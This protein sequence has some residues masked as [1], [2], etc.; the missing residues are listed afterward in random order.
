MLSVET[1][2]QE[3]ITA[4]KQRSFEI[5]REVLRSCSELAECKSEDIER[6]V[7]RA[8]GE[9]EHAELAGWFFLAESGELTNVFR[10]TPNPISLCS[11]FSNGLRG[12]PWCLSQLNAGTAVLID[13]VNE[14]PE[15]AEIDRQSLKDAAVRSVAL[16]PSNSTS[17]GHTI[18]ILLSVSNE[19]NWSD[20]INEQ[21]ALLETM[22]SIASQRMPIREKPQTVVKYFEQL[23]A[24][25]ANGMA[26]VN[27]EGQIITTN[28]AL[29]NAL[30]YSD[31]E[32]RNMKCDDLINPAPRSA[33]NALLKNLSEAALENQQIE[34]ILLRKDRSLMAARINI[35]L[36]KEHPCEDF[37]ALLAIEDVT[38]QRNAEKEL[39]R[40]RTEVEAL[41]VA[42]HPVPGE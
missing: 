30:G 8:V 14:L 24:T 40:R 38:E 34:R 36:V 12:L 41:A 11:A 19:T 20:E 35:S 3:D 18:L 31:D 4:G 33:D 25:S 17:T 16:L 7:W 26:L 32:L 39:S 21:C 1:K 9:I 10:S 5:A 42:T 22:F 23:L 13:D 37:L 2:P 29:R 28:R 15:F 27:N 6:V